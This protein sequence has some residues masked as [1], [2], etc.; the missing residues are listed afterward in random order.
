[1]EQG[2]QQQLSEKWAR[3][4]Q[5]EL[6]ESER[7][8]PTRNR[9]RVSPQR[10]GMDHVTFVYLGHRSLLPPPRKPTG[11]VVLGGLLCPLCFANSSLTG[12]KG[13]ERGSEDPTG[14]GCSPESSRCYRNLGRAG[15]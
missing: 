11:A 9:P 1:M 3:V 8:L 10:Q 12:A 15:G 5:E 7:E 2:R 13:K 6:S 4:T 14:S